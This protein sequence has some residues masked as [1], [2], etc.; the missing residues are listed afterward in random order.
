MSVAVQGSRIRERQRKA[1][2]MFIHAETPVAPADYLVSA[3]IDYLAA[4]SPADFALVV[5]Q[6]R[7]P[8]DPDDG[9]AAG[10]QDAA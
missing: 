7:P 9:P 5:A 1:S 10:R 6:A 4:L 3:V 2:S 8:I